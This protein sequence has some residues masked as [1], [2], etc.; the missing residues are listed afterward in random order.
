MNIT[1]SACNKSHK[2]N[3]KLKVSLEKLQPGQKLRLKC[4][5]CGEPIP[6]SRDDLQGEGGAQITPPGPP[7]TSWLE[8]GLFDGDDEVVS[9]IPQALIVMQEGAARDTVNTALSGLGYRTETA[10]Q[11]ESV[12]KKMQFVNYTCVVL[13]RD[14][15]SGS[16]GDDPFHRYMCAMEMSRRRYLFYVL[17]GSE[18]KTFYNLQALSN[19]ANLV[20]N[21]EHLSQIGLILRKAIPEYEDLF[22]PYMDE[23]KIHGKA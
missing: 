13:D 2:A 9:D 22:G 15:M 17:V 7:D 10:D 23:L 8:D 4:S 16:L 21:S 11:A 5:Q 20:I 18:F 6:L 1:C 3:D 14:S 19:S 12:I